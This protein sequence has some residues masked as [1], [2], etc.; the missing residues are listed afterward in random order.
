MTGI[1]AA[2]TFAHP[3][4]NLVKKDKILWNCSNSYLVNFERLRST[5]MSVRAF[6]FGLKVLDQRNA[7]SNFLL[8]YICLPC[9]KQLMMHTGG[10]ELAILSHI[11]VAE[12]G[13]SLKRSS[14]LDKG[15][16]L[17][18][19]TMTHYFKKSWLIQKINTY[20]LPIKTGLLVNSKENPQAK[21]YN[22]ETWNDIIV[23]QACWS[24]NN[25]SFQFKHLCKH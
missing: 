13:T 25:N 10:K 5:G 21:E 24:S 19:E 20:Y 2:V 12:N 23:A 11:P 1:K 15:I 17:A 7:H 9:I 8:S 3:L 4:L 14:P 16:W 22:K 6:F 18:W